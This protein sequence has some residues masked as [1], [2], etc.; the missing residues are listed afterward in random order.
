M[1]RILFIK[2]LY[3]ES[4]FYNNA[5]LCL[6][7]CKRVNSIPYKHWLCMAYL[8]NWYFFLKQLGQ[9]D[10]NAFAWKRDIQIEQIPLV[11]HPV[12]NF[13]LTRNNTVM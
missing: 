6:T 2:S 7:S 11:Y 9:S 10:T 8:L 12:T 1:R 5:R 13:E 4:Y 3:S